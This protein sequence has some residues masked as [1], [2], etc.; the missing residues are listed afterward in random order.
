V[1]N[2]IRV[3][4]YRKLR[5]EGL[6][7]LAK[8]V[9]RRTQ[10]KIHRTKFK[11]KSKRFFE[12]LR[13]TPFK[14]KN[15]TSLKLVIENYPSS[16]ILERLLKNQ[17]LIL[18]KGPTNWG[19]AS[20]SG[21]LEWHKD[22][23]NKHAWSS[24]A[25]GLEITIPLGAG[26]I[27]RP[28][29]LGRLHQFVQLGLCFVNSEA[30]D[31]RDQAKGLAA[32]L[33]KDFSS[34]NP[35]FRGPQ[36]MCAMDVG[37]RLANIILGCRLLGSDFTVAHEALLSF[38]IRRHLFFI[39]NN[40]ENGPGHF[41]GNHYLGDLAGL[42]FAYPHS[43][44]NL[45]EKGLPLYQEIR[46][47][48]LRQF[49]EDGGNFEGSTYY[50]RL[51]AELGILSLGYLADFLGIEIQNDVELFGR[52]SRICDFSR[53]LTCGKNGYV[54]QI[55]DNDSGH[56]FIF[57]PLDFEKEDLHHLN[58]INALSSWPKE[59]S[60]QGHFPSL[61]TGFSKRA[62]P[63]FGTPTAASSGD[64]TFLKN[65]REALAARPN[66]NAYQVKVSDELLKGSRFSFPQ[67]GLYGI[68]KAE[69]M[70]LIR[71][72]DNPKDSQGGHR[73]FDQL[74][75]Q[76]VDGENSLFRDP[77]SFIY[78]PS[79]K[80]RN[81]FRSAQAHHVPYSEDDVDLSD[82]NLF[83]LD[84]YHGQC[85]Y[86]GSEGFLGFFQGQRDRYFRLILFANETL[87]IYD[88]SEKNRKL[89]A[90]DFKERLFSDRYGHL[91]KDAE[92]IFER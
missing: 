20:Q 75:F 42:A 15:L 53:T 18:S 10:R 4:I 27:K 41:V 90:L 91:V 12:N 3:H 35:E 2:Q 81:A 71:C 33:L 36:W 88:W 6:S 82:L 32:A 65:A 84:R 37:I 21:E 28:W 67:F 31:V 40:L 26:D 86:F 66:L 38:E 29:E 14:L 61:L 50:H 57:N 25:W 47:E 59:G 5:E 52:I 54:P 9:H 22:L 80:M 43:E 73:H 51:S 74:S 8:A 76:L 63:P 44:E 85:L 68:K 83:Q 19:R 13:Q 7:G 62:V 89:V 17:Y 24:K 34:A 30:T 77:G 58:L 92:S 70:L 23:I 46:R 56:L 45:N 79:P 78:T 48:I 55:G 60:S 39:E 11:L 49:L 72:G 16:E 1:L 69:K 87:E 64:P